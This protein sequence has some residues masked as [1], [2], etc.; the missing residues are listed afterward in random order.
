M[1]H[2]ILLRQLKLGSEDVPFVVVGVLRTNGPT[3]IK[4]GNKAI[5]LPN[6]TIEGWVG[7]HCT[8]NEIVTNALECLKEGTSRTLDL[9]TCQGGTMAVY[10][11][12]YLPKRKL[13]IF[14]HVPIA[15][16][17]SG[18]AKS[19]NFSVTLIDKTASK[20]RF[21]DADVILKSIEDMGQKTN[22]RNTFAVIAMMGERDQEYAEKLAKLGVHYIGIVAGKKRATEVLTYLRSS[23]LSEEALSRIKA[24][25]GIY[26]R[27][28]TAEEIALSIMAEI[29]EI[30][31]T[32]NPS[33]IQDASQSSVATSP[34]TRRAVFVD[35]V[36]GMTV[37]DSSEFFSSIS[38]QKVYFCSES[39]KTNFESNPGNYI[40]Q[41][42]NS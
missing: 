12:P 9:T 28:I 11:E 18:L 25:A 27:S 23:G 37:D 19:L 16:A 3:A 26:I 17:L 42:N 32:M 34:E 36:C 41:Q 8:E 38:G 24:P 5:I 29:V 7:G 35:P 13:L 33:S 14:G 22:S 6:G 10:L 21:P 30:S 31:R 39:C 20:E 40:L 15:T 1:M 4:A 2:D